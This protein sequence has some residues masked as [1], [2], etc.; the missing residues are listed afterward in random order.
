M[1]GGTSLTILS[2]W[3]NVDVVGTLMEAVALACRV[4]PP[5][6]DDRVNNDNQ[7]Q[8]ERE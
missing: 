2:F 5:C 3:D 8:T 4:T 6:E 1:A 7:Q